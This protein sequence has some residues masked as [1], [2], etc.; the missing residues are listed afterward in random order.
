MIRVKSVLLK[1]INLTPTTKE[2]VVRLYHFIK[3]FCYLKRK[4]KITTEDHM[5]VFESFLGKQYGCSPKALFLAMV[6]DPAYRDYQKVWMFRNPEQYRFLEQ[7]ENTRVVKYGSKEYEN[8]YAKAKYWITNYHLPAG[9][10]KGKDQ[11]YVQ[12]WH[13]T[14]LKKIG[15]DVGEPGTLSRDKK[16]AWKEYCMEGT[17]ID[18]MPSPSPFYTEKIKSAFRL[19][20][21]AKVLE[22]GYPRND[23]L[24]QMKEDFCQ[25]IRKN[26]SIPQDKKVMLYAPTWRDNRHVPGQGYVYECGMNFELMKEELGEEWVILF[27]AHYLI[28]NSFDFEQYKGFVINASEYDDVNHLYAISNL[29]ITDYSSVFFDYAN[30]KRPILFYMYDYEEYRNEMRDFYFSPSE[31]PGLVVKEQ[32]DLM[33]A[34]KTLSKDT[35]VPGE[36][37]ERFNQKYNPY[38]EPCSSRMISEILKAG[39]EKE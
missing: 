9:I 8:C 5:V 7:Y 29:L 39:C 6:K 34:I 33:M 22:Y 27:R 38:Q 23:F 4:R 13:G 37:Y 12:T 10:V 28:S 3:K 31:L 35:F 15:C 2:W 11:I 32:D 14:P 1:L 16:R 19:Q 17:I 36:D 18:Y 21:Q 25:K 24:L 20:K 30:L 26:F